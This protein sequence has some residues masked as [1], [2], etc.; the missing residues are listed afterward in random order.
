MERYKVKWSLSSETEKGWRRLEKR[1][2][3]VMHGL[4]SQTMEAGLYP[5]GHKKT[6]K[7]FWQICNSRWSLY[8]Q[9]GELVGEEQDWKSAMR[10]PQ[11]LVILMIEISPWEMLLFDL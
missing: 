9:Y 3:Q 6:F 7:T 4:E 8:P 2:E 1:R 11:S 10:L 5:T